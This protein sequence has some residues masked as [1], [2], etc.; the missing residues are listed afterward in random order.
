MVWDGANKLIRRFHSVDLPPADFIMFMSTWACRLA[1]RRRRKDLT[2]TVH[3][4]AHLLLDQ[5]SLQT[6]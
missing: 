6:T 1:L 5:Y 2:C 3:T 4:T